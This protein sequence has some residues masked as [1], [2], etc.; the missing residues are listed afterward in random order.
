MNAK[1]DDSMDAGGGSSGVCEGLRCDS[2]LTSCDSSLTRQQQNDSA[3][4]SSSERR[5]SW[6]FHHS[7]CGKLGICTLKESAPPIYATGLTATILMGE[8]RVSFS[9]QTGRGS[10]T[11]R[12]SLETTTTVSSSEANK[13]NIINTVLS[14]PKLE[15]LSTNNVT[16]LRSGASGRGH[17]G[18]GGSGLCSG[19]GT[20][21]ASGGGVSTPGGG[22]LGGGGGAGLSSLVGRSGTPDG[23]RNNMTG[24]ES[25]KVSTTEAGGA[26]K[27][28]YTDT[29]GSGS[30]SKNSSPETWVVLEPQVKSAPNNNQNNNHNN[31][32]SMDVIDMNQVKL[33]EKKDIEMDQIKLQG[34][35]SE[36]D[37][38]GM[39][40]KTFQSCQV[41]I[42]IVDKDKLYDQPQVFATISL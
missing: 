26:T 12:G 39:V 6:R 38:E 28:S 17:I 40:E 33:Q 14:T 11:K 16:M 35:S 10:L 36:E 25:T 18:G 9:P 34:G 1:I 20:P 19:A 42:K 32:I 30:N 13:K 24:E 5:M 29:K 8:G 31:G 22:K 23:A 3:R 21:G 15:G 27:G 37:E 41:A 4:H 2:G 7:R